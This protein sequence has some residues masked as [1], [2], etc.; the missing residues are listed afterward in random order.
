MSF[1]TN[2]AIR[3]KTKAIYIPD[4]IF[5]E[6]TAGLNLFYQ[7]HA[8]VFTT[9][10]FIVFLSLKTINTDF[11]TLKTQKCDATFFVLITFFVNLYIS[12]L[13]ARTEFA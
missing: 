7:Q 8:M 5:M 4:E 6:C 12:V 13:R 11:L 2:T 10:F 3:K 1:D 9:S